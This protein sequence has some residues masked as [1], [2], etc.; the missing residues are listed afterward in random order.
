MPS[1]PPQFSAPRVQRTTISTPN[2]P[3]PAQEPGG[4]W[5]WIAGLIA[6]AGAS[7]FAIKQWLRPSLKVSCEIET[8]PSMLTASSTPALIAPDLA[9]TIRIEPGVASVPVGNPALTA[10]D[11]A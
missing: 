6:L 10:G 1:A 9:F 2:V 11:E 8:G 5:G 7:G 4:Y 3:L